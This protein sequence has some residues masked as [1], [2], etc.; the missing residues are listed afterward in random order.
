MSL[1]FVSCG[2]LTAEEKSLGQAIA[3]AINEIDGLESY[4]AD[5]QT[6]LEGITA[7]IFAKLNECVAFV[8]IMQERGTV[9][10]D[11]HDGFNRASLW[12]EQE[13]AVASFIR[14]TLGRKIEPFTF[15]QKGIKREG[16]R[17]QLMLNA[18]E[19]EHQNEVLGLFAEHAVPALKRLA[20]SSAPEPV[21]NRESPL[22]QFPF[23]SG[24]IATEPMAINP[25]FQFTL[26]ITPWS[27]GNIKGLAFD[28]DDKI[29]I[30][31]MLARGR[32][33]FLNETVS[34]TRHAY[35]ILYATQSSGKRPDNLPIP[36]NYQIYVQRDGVIILQF[37]QIQASSYWQLISILMEGFHAA[38]AVFKKLGLVPRAYI[39][40]R[41][42]LHAGRH[43]Y[44]PVL[45][46]MIDQRAE[47]NLE[48]PFPVA[49][50]ELICEVL[51][52]SSE[53]I[54][55]EKIKTE[56]TTAWDNYSGEAFG[57]TS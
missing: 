30:G 39:R 52:A 53:S 49:F 50:T 28:D 29:E 40:A 56:L 5:T 44:K 18:V 26:Q 38:R 19:F 10:Y 54:N 55:R 46:G 47:I 36:P 8:T 51:S 1:V 2:Q 42:T 15:I 17:A 25:N 45:S 12:I 20:A 3:A 33:S 9:N 32:M 4:F 31:K 23:G 35:G 34:Q 24:P 57:R 7:N 41:A 16:L 37:A 11:G 22:G 14:H 13:I 48:D 43:D 6:S 21:Q 27:F